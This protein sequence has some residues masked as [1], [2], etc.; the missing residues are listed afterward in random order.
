M[1]SGKSG[2][3]KRVLPALEE[4]YDEIW[5][6]GLREVYDPFTEIPISETIRQKIRYTGYLYREEPSIPTSAE[7]DP[8]FFLL[9]TGGGGDGEG[10]VDWVLR[11]YEQESTLT[12]PLTIL[13]GP[14]MPS[15]LQETF[16]RRASRFPQIKT[17]EFASCPESL[18]RQARGI[19]AM[20]GYNTFCE[21]LSFDKPS[22]IIPR[23]TP[24]R[25]QLLRI[26]Y[27]SA[28]KLCT[29]L[30]DNGRRDPT[31][32]VQALKAL[33]T[34]SVPSHYF[35]PRLLNGLEYLKERSRHW[36]E[37][38]CEVLMNRPL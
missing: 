23:E 31:E 21:I 29:M 5:V 3:R 33:E 34:Q 32:M 26:T 20:G 17:L 25:E 30:Y 18:I 15:S 6:Y 38:P 35:I 13:L 8:P 37:Q 14:F 1:R 36:L 4:L 9:M 2:S 12:Y 10:V 22:L 11:A 7:S 16:K 28:L 24:R 19:I 27:A